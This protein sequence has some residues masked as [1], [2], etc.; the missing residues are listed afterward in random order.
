LFQY[1]V[2]EAL[3]HE[4]Q[5]EENPASGSSARFTSDSSLMPRVRFATRL[6]TAEKIAC[7]V[8]GPLV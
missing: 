1:T 6:S 2:R 5:S 7:D 8:P 4:R 3:V